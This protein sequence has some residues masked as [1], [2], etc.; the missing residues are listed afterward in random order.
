M[1]TFR[2]IEEKDQTITYWYFPEGGKAHGVITV[3]M[4]NQ[5]VIITEV[6]SNDYEYDISPDQL[7][8]MA[9][10]INKMVR[11]NGGTNFVELA[12]EPVHS[13]VYGDHAVD[14]ISELVRNGE[15]P[16]EGEVFWY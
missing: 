11:E 5:E 16:Q 15:V 12:T 6:A 9:E 4:G 1:V 14:R 7:N 8:E 3:D 2:M 10:V 13:I